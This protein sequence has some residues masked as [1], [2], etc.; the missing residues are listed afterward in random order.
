MSDFEVTRGE[1]RAAREAQAAAHAERT[2]ARVA[3]RTAKVAGEPVDAAADAMAVARDTHA[4]AAKAAALALERFAV[5]A[6]PH[7][8]LERLNDDTPFLLLPLRIETRFKAIAQR[9]RRGPSTELWVRVFPDRC[10]INSF[11]PVPTKNELANLRAYWAQIWR[12]GGAEAGDR[13][14]WRSLVASHGSGRAGWLVDGF[15]PANAADR[16]VRSSDDEVILVVVTAEPLA[17]AEQAALSTYWEARWRAGDDADAREAAL[18]DLRAAVGAGAGG[19]LTATE[20]F[21]LADPPAP[22]RTLASNPCTVAFLVVAEVPGAK[23]QSWTNAPRVE[24]LPE[25]L[26]LILEADGVATEVMGEPI[27]SPL[28]V[29]PDPSAP[30]G[31]QLE[32]LDGDLKLPDE[33]LW[34]ADF[35]EA[36]RIGLGF[37]V[38]L[39]QEQADAGFDRLYV[40][41]TRLTS[42]PDESRQE[43][44]ALFADHHRSRDGLSLLPQGAPTN[45]TEAAGS[46][47]TRD[48]DADASFDT[49]AGTTA[50]AIDPD[51]AARPDGQWLAGA[52]GLDPAA[53][54]GLPHAA[55]FD[56]RDARAMQTLLWP[57]TLGYLLSTML[58]GVVSEEAVED[59]RRFFTRYVSGRGTVPALRIGDQPYGIL[60]TTAFSRLSWI[61]K[62]SELQRGWQQERFLPRLFEMSQVADEDW[63]AL[64]EKAPSVGHEGVDAHETLLGIL[65]LHPSSVEFHYRYAESLDLLFNRLN[66]SGIAG[67]FLGA[68]LDAALDA[69]ALDLLAR[70]GY[71]HDGERKIDLLEK[72]FLGSQ[73]LLKGPLIDDRPLS[74]SQGIRV[75]TADGTNYLE[76]LGKAAQ[77]SLEAVRSEEGFVDAPPTAQL[78]LLAR[79]AVMLGYADA[80]Y[81]FHRSHGLSPAALVRLRTEAPF[82]HVETS[83]RSESRFAPLYTAATAVGG[84]SAISVAEHVTASLS[85]APETER[86]DEQIKALEFLADATTA[87]LERALAEHIDTVS[88]RFD[89]WRLG[90]VALQL[91]RMRDNGPGA[92]GARTGIHLGAYGWL[93]NVRP[94]P[95]VLEEVQLDAE[96]EQVFQRP[97]DLPL[98]RDSSNGGFIHAPSLNHAVTAAVLRSGYLAN[99]SRT[100]PDAMSVNLSSERVRLALDVLE[101]MRN[102]QSLTAL[103]GYRLERDLHDGHTIAE[104]DSFIY[105]LRKRFPLHALKLSKTA[106]HPDVA[107]ASI[108]QLEARNVVNG[109]ALADHVRRT[110]DA[111]YP[112]GL[113]GMPPAGVDQQRVID[114]AVD[115]LRN[116]RDAVAD[117]A[118]AE[119]VHQAA[120][121]NF[122][123]V[124]ATLAA[125]SEGH[126]PPDPDV[127]R[128]PSTGQVLTH[129][130]G[131]QLQ[132]G[133]GQPATAPTPRSVAEPALNQW[134]LDTLPAP[135][136]IACRA[137]WEDPVSAAERSE[138]VTMGQ[139]GLQPLD[140]LEL[141]RTADDPAMSELDDRVVA[142]TLAKR[143]PRPDARL[144]ISYMEA[145]PGT[146]TV[147]EAAPLI[148]HARGLVSAARPLRA[149]DVAPP[150]AA[151]DRMDATASV[152]R[153]RVG[154]VLATAKR[155]Q[156]DA[157]GFTVPADPVAVVTGIDGL[158]TAA[159]AL[160]ERA[161]RLGLPGSG[162]GF[163]L[164]W[165]RDRYVQ[166]VDL[167]RD[168]AAALT[169]R[170]AEIDARLAAYD[171]LAPAV[172]DDER[173]R[174]LAEIESAIS[175]DLDPPPA[176]PTAGRTALAAKRTAFVALRDKLAGIANG[177][178]ATLA[179]LLAAVRAVGPL[180]PFAQGDLDVTATDEAVVAFA[181]Q[182]TA[183]VTSMSGRLAERVTAGERALVAHDAAA[184][185]P[186]RLAA[187]Q[188]AADGLL[189]ENFILIPE[190]TVTAAQGTAWQQALQETTSGELL[191]YLREDTE[192]EFPVDE[193]LC[194]AARVRGP[195]AHLEQIGILAAALGRV[196][197]ELTPV[198]LPHRAGERWLALDYPPGQA[199]DS[200]RLLYTAVYTTAFDPG[201]PQC[202]L[203]LDEWTEV[204][205]GPTAATGVAL[206][207]DQPNSEPPQAMLL[208]TP[209]TWDGKWQ[210]EDLL[211]A[212][213]DTLRLARQRA[214]EPAQ[215][216][217]TAY[218][219]FLPATITAVTRHGLTIALAL[220]ANNN[221]FTAVDDA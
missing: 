95:R 76:W 23:D 131:L 188:Q 35:K 182:L 65:G 136:A 92:Q 32:Q 54:A 143:T 90:F 206:N 203:L 120:Q 47:Y 192:V 91:E 10:L 67:G 12:S 4:S 163:A 30:A 105:A 60:T 52:L 89:A 110:G 162:W 155:L 179:G 140:L 48:D 16:P 112:F 5:F 87:R 96:M 39:T 144:E 45:N 145:G 169:T 34:L 1:L 161:S 151:T 165:R 205:P 137:H 18:D 53:V 44:E 36:Q 187:M 197:P 213:P 199:M 221:V 71:R 15:P 106:T 176:T 113:T 94:E 97:Q 164:V 27:P 149:S 6:D 124:G 104:V 58:H 150:G 74:E 68:L 159:V 195:L 142:H 78:Y 63:A 64:A 2:A 3:L 175:A 99:A 119:G 135:D 189:G 156:T 201:E 141:V 69:P 128:T 28:F 170:L 212:L 133:L 57:A 55:G 111:T 62:R 132:P 20:P 118:L 108:D 215:L 184:D 79:H 214:V 139:L 177:S 180:A 185:A 51:P 38:G 190:F 194:G 73:G 219:R 127:V 134:L 77:E 98:M 186:A 7:D 40:L 167:L 88:Y 208:V 56:Q 19:L 114:K 209:A 75:W 41:G 85:A 130:I 26:V 43:L 181:A 217:A 82:I 202:G 174:L 50:F 129:R 207:F 158:V 70:L 11:E 103:L 24:L 86:L 61:E 84:S 198:Q 147:F 22:D 37:V 102:G 83:G 42:D 125:Y 8:G 13:A 204:I 178:T 25:R 154:A 157:G 152:E 218:A 100:D 193:W 211:Q 9:G 216:D 148:A 200:E 172:P 210:W 123:R 122:D 107:G 173:L 101:G 33:L 220:A 168:K 17:P 160:L 80:S 115:R 116:V 21:N 14:A 171:A 59:T 183:A 166:T 72:Y 49:R 121:G 93:E 66:L 191:R 31:E 81:H 146:V 46:A 109:L 196:E 117:L 138:F 29:G 153:A 126:H